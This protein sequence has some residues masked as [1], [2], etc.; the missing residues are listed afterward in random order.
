VAPA[1]TTLELAPARPLEHHREEL[2]EFGLL[3]PLVVRCGGRAVPVS[4]GHQR[5]LLAVL[6]LDA[7]RVVPVGEIAECLWGAAAPPSAAVSVRNY[8]RRLRQALG[9]EGPARISFRRG[10]YV[11]SA[12]EDELDVS[13][14]AALLA[15]ARAA[16]RVG[17]WDKTAA[18]ARQALGLWRS[19]PLCDI[20][21]DVLGLRERPQL[22][23]SRLQAAEIRA[24]A[25][26][27][28]GRHAEALTGLQRLAADHPLREHLHALLMLALY[29]CGRQAE[30]L[31]AYQ[32]A[33]GVLVTDLGIEPCTELQNLHHQI[34]T[35]DPALNLP[36][37]ASTTDR[38]G[39]STAD[40]AVVSSADRP[41]AG[42]AAPIFRG[43]V[44]FCR[45]VPLSCRR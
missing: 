44:R 36:P 24:E 30:A 33:R 15:S 37:Q 19:E 16:A 17:S 12:G 27:W 29:R 41:G 26:L 35:A 39:R 4:Q 38:A 32:Q 31:T 34:L 10:G 28:L 3:G 5:T 7:N 1:V 43:G 2:M 25:E 22:A 13:R 20:E 21:S 9:E 18:L 11:I 23:E 42:R 40:G 45:H 14:F 8:V 6:L